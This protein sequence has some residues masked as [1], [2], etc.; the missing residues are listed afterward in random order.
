MS[1]VLCQDLQLV[2]DEEH[3]H[4]YDHEHHDEHDHD[5]GQGEDHDHGHG[6][7]HEEP[8]RGPYP[9]GVGPKTTIVSYLG[10]NSIDEIALKF[11]LE[12]ILKHPFIS[13]VHCEH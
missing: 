5:H 2:S 12:A 6:E 9:V 11:W 13:D 10:H 7:H 1:V 4:D 8:A 3:D